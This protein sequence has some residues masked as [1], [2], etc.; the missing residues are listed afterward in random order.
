[1]STPPSIPPVSLVLLVDGLGPGLLGA[2]GC[3]WIDTPTID[4]LAAQAIL[5]E[6]AIADSTDPETAIAAFLQGRH[7]WAPADPEAQPICGQEIFSQAH[8]LFASDDPAIAAAAGYYGFDRVLQLPPL[9]GPPGESPSP[10]PDIG[11]T[12]LAACFAQILS[13]LDS[14][15]WPLLA[16]VHLSSLARIWDAPLSLRNRF[17]EDDDPLP[18]ACGQPPETLTTPDS[19]D[20]DEV[21]G[22]TRVLAGQ[23]ECLDSC[24]GVVVD[25]LQRQGVFQPALIALCGL[26]GLAVGHHGQLGAP[27][28]YL[29]SDVIDVAMLVKPPARPGWVGVRQHR[30]TQPS[31]VLD[32]VSQLATCERDPGDA[33]PDPAPAAVVLGDGKSRAIRTPAWLLTGP[34]DAPGLFVKPDDRWDVNPVQDRCQEIVGLL[35]QAWER[36]RKTIEAPDSSATPCVLAPELV[37]P[38]P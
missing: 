1:M 24:L 23:I 31:D 29:F 12:H 36:I 33:W 2:G 10:R 18:P 30:L 37:E 32:L 5:F 8:S 19:P 22:L 4:H 15:D 35:E 21:L 7:V 14:A 34:T 13:L 16:V 6:N 17:C 27:P 3:S 38:A 9:P 20:P 11:D 25:E 26:R 28:G